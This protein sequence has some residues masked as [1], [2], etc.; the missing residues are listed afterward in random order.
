M[1]EKVE[2]ISKLTKKATKQE[3]TDTTAQATTRFSQEEPEKAA[4]HE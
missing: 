3:Q 1:P 4:G 2:P